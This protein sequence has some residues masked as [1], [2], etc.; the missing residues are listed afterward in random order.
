MGK[1]CGPVWVIAEQIDCRILA[2]S[3]QLI[4]HGRKLATALDT[5]VDAILLGHKMEEHP[6][7]LFAAGGDRVYLG[8]D[9]ELAVYQPEIRKTCKRKKA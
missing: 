9:P 3:F 5:S 1:S 6:R 8:N 7:Q 2:V 4:N